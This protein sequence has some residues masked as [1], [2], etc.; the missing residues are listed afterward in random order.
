MKHFA[1]WWWTGLA[2]VALSGCA[3]HSTTRLHRVLDHEIN[4]AVTSVPNFRCTV[5]AHRGSSVKHR[6]NTLAALLAAE[7][8][9]QYAF[10][11]FDVQFTRDRQIVLFH[12]QTLLRTYRKFTSVAKATYDDLVDLTGG[13]ISRYEDAISIITKP[14][15]VEIKS[16]GD[17]R[18]DR[19]LADTIIADLRARG[20]DRHVMVSSIS[21][22][23]LR[24]I[25]KRYPEIPTGLI[26]WLT[27]S[28][29]IHWDLLTES[30][31]YKVREAQAD[32]LMLYVANLRN[33]EN[34][35]DLKPKNTTV[36]FWD[37]DDR[38]YLVHQ[39]FTD[40]LWV[41]RFVR[42]QWW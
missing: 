42:R 14:V 29:Y 11:E 7:R 41:R 27:A 25:N 39:S 28:T 15:N 19:L 6:E 24:Y 1:T 33:I 23:I 38:M 9:P 36:I 21:S 37:F 16:Q 17:D 4:R 3:T 35:L 26:F 13:D 31:F 30:L 22:E 8:D 18:E 32:Y 34:L 2:A 5:G 12:D 40:R 20:R 10:V